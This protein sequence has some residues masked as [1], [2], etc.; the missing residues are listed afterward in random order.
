MTTKDII[1]SDILHEIIDGKIDELRQE[2][3]MIAY[4]M[5][6]KALYNAKPQPAQG[7]DALFWKEIKNIF[8]E[9]APDSPQRLWSF[10][11]QWA[12]DNNVPGA[13]AIYQHGGNYIR[14]G[15]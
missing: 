15:Y 11:A 12:K 8:S 9:E 5:T 7:Q 10:I 3:R 13:I 2:M 1:D 6:M 4:D 14:K